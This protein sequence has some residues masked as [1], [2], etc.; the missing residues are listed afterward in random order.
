MKKQL[1]FFAVSKDTEFDRLIVNP[2]VINS[3]MHGRNAFTKTIAP[4]HL[5]SLLRLEQDEV[6]RVSSDDLSEFYYTFAVSA[7]R[8]SRNAI[9]IAFQPSEVQHLNCFCSS[10][11]TSPVYIALRTLAMGDGL[12]VEIAQQS[13]VNLLRIRAACMRAHETL[14]HRRP[15][16]RSPFI[17][18]LTIDDIYR[19]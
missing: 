5:L 9:G 19:R 2:T 15:I 7:K 13:H 1:A 18:L 4:G 16:P 12:A 14:M 6:L 11:H 8:A 10:K 3:R 17:E